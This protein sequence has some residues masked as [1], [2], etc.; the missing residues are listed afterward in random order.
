MTILPDGSFRITAAPG[1][2]E[3]GPP[4][5]VSGIVVVLL[6][7]ALVHRGDV[8]GLARRVRAGC[9]LVVFVAA[10]AQAA[11]AAALWHGDL[12]SPRIDSAIEGFALALVAGSRVLP[13]AV[14]W[15]WVIAARRDR[16]AAAVRPARPSTGAPAPARSAARRR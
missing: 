15:G 3:L 16:P 6:G 12:P 9:G 8:A 7:T 4:Y 10:L 13:Y 14:V 2:A 5:A 1:I 11:V